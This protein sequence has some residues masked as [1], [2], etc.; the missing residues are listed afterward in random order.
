MNDD[1]FYDEVASELQAKTMVPGVW[2]RA[3]AETGG[4][5]DRARALYIKYR[6]AQ[7]AH[8]RSQRLEEER[9]AAMEATKQRALSGFRR[10]AY[11]LL[12]VVFGLL[13]FVFAL[14]IIIPFTEH[15]GAAIGGAIFMVVIAF[16]FGLATHKCYKAAQR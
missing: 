3:F 8:A 10:F 16:L 7:M 13:T 9:R 4:E 1:A 2:A 12:M 5:M 11:G 6:V 15:S 14:G